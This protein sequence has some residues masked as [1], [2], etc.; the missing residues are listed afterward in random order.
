MGRH[1]EDI[2]DRFRRIRLSEQ[3]SSGWANIVDF[4]LS[5]LVPWV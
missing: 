5:N 3:T 1:W 2:S 4:A